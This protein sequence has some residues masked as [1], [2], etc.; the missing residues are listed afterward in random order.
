MKDASYLNVRLKSFKG[1]QPKAGAH[2]F[3]TIIIANK[4]RHPIYKC[5]WSHVIT[6]LKIKKILFCIILLTNF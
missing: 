6:T 5:S 4:K 2:F 1:H 3:I